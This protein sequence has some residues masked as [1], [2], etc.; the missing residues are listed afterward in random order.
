MPEY[1]GLTQAGM[2]DNKAFEQIAPQLSH[3]T[4]YA[5]K[6]Y[7]DSFADEAATFTLLTPIKKE[8]GQSFLDAADMWLSTAV[9]RVR[10]PIESFFNWLE[11]KTAIQL[12]SKVRSYQGL[13][14][15]VFGRIA[16]A[17]AAKII[18]CS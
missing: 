18:L 17:F 11:E 4:L 7:S 1:I 5:D 2:N 8:K 14:V 9:S 10:Q 6:A 12:A 13:M 15:H 3:D 16:A